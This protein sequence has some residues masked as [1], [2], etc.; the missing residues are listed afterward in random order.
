[1]DVSAPPAQAMEFED[2]LEEEDCRR[3]HVHCRYLVRTLL[4]EPMTRTEAD[5]SSV[6][7]VSII[8][9]QSLV[10]LGSSQNP[11]YDHTNVSV[12]ST[13]EIHVGIICA[14]MP[15]VRLLLVRLF[16]VLGDSSYDSSN[17]QSSGDIY[18]RMP[19]IASRNHALVELSSR[20]ESIPR[21]EYGRIELVRTFDVQYSDGD[22]TRLVSLREFEK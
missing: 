12:W 14:S 5:E 4:T 3:G 2:A 17:Y 19:R 15:A 18:G 7:I 11:T 22:E 9:L 13:V 21:P 8:R 1:M 20:G 10:D 16:P 6:T